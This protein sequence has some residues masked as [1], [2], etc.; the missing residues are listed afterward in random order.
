MKISR[1]DVRSMKNFP[2]VLLPGNVCGY[3]NGVWDSLQIFRFKKFS[4]NATFYS[5][6]Y[7]NLSNFLTFH[8]T[9]E[10]Y[11]RIIHTVENDIKAGITRS[12]LL[13]SPAP[14]SSTFHFRP[15][16]ME[17]ETGNSVEMV[18]YPSSGLKY[19]PEKVWVRKRRGV[20]GDEERKEIN[21][22]QWIPNFSFPDWHFSNTWHTI[23]SDRFKSQRSKQRHF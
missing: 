14:L 10:E 18:G 3:Y 21:R 4:V 20:N 1:K 2:S 7:F 12:F 19:R 17:R 8:S 5:V 16:F 11:S 13:R 15:E 6:S 23:L 22:P 9:T